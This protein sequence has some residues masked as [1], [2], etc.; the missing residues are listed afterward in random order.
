[1]NRNPLL[2]LRFAQDWFKGQVKGHGG[3][4]SFSK[5]GFKYQS[6]GEKSPEARDMDECARKQK[7]P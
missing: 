7:H 5:V 6:H 4:Q 3:R 1:M 2:S